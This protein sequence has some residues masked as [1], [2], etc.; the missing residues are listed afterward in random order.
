[1]S[2]DELFAR[3]PL[4]WG[5]RGD[6][7]VWEAMRDRLRGQEPP[8]NQF[9]ARTLFERTFTEV[10]GASLDGPVAESASVYLPQFRVGSG[11][12][13]GHVSLHF[14]KFTGLP[15]LLDRWAASAAPSAWPEP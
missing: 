12:S 14:W 13:D 15:I 9:A 1:M 5:L 3:P 2:L 6:P 7:H 10:T 4:R 8:G 11:M